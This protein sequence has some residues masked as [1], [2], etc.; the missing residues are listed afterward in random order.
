MGLYHHTWFISFV[1][2]WNPVC[3]GYSSDHVKTGSKLNFTFF[4]TMQV[5]I[6]VVVLSFGIVLNSIQGL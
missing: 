2:L 1:D 3:K 6:G 4:E 5:L